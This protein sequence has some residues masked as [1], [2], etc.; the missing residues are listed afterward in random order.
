MFFWA[1]QVPRRVKI[2]KP[3]SAYI[4]VRRVRGSTSDESGKVAPGMEIAYAVTFTAESAEDHAAELVVC[5]ERE[6]FLVP[7]TCIGRCAAA[8]L[9]SICDACDSTVDAVTSHHTWPCVIS[10]SIQYQACLDRPYQPPEQHTGRCI[11]VRYSACT[12]LDH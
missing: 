4:S 8:A 3:A 7:V 9:N 10:I 2:E 12:P 6:R 11:Y 1:F 5:T